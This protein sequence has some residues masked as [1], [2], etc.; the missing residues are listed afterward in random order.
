MGIGEVKNKSFSV[1][2]KYLKTRHVGHELCIRIRTYLEYRWEQ[3]HDAKGESNVEILGLLSENLKAELAS[4]IHGPTLA[5][6]PLF[7]KLQSESSMTMR[8]LILRAVSQMHLAPQDWMFH[9][10]EEATHMS[11]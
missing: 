1:L 11:M 9:A 10:G 7:L 3:H 2:R 6:H 5:I 8:R 4:A